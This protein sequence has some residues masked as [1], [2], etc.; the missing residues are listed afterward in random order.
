MK[1]HVRTCRI[2]L[3]WVSASLNKVV[4]SGNS[5]RIS[6]EVLNRCWILD[7]LVT[8]AARSTVICCIV[9]WEKHQEERE[10]D[11]ERKKELEGVRSS[12]RER[13]LEK[14]LKRER[15]S[16]AREKDKIECGIERKMK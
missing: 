1:N 9:P 16:K 2:D 15:V 10:T 12:D 6:G 11:R 13:E 3:S 5:L 4:S 7:Q 14:G 8:V